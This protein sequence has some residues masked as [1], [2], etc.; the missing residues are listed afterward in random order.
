MVVEIVVKAQ[1]QQIYNA[2]LRCV[3]RVTELDHAVCEFACIAADTHRRK[4]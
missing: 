3:M 2:S 4:S 1:Q